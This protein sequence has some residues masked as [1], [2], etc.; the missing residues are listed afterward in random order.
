MC[1]VLTQLLLTH[2]LMQEDSKREFCTEKSLSNVMKYL[3]AQAPRLKRPAIVICLS[4]ACTE[5]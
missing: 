1:R 5:R 4:S 3:D 2:T